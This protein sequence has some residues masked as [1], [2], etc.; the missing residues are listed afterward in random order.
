MGLVVVEPVGRVQ[1]VGFQFGVV[2][3]SV[4]E[5]ELVVAQ[6]FEAVLGVDPYFVLEVVLGV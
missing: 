2:L 4:L 6:D 5:A 3:G 1:S